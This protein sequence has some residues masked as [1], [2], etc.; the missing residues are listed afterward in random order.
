MVRWFFMLQH[1]WLSFKLRIITDKQLK[2]GSN[3]WN[4]H[5]S[6]SVKSYRGPNIRICYILW[7]NWLATAL[8]DNTRW[9]RTNSSSP[10]LRVSIA[11]HWQDLWVIIRI[12]WLYRYSTKLQN[13]IVGELSIPF[14]MRMLNKIILIYEASFVT[15]VQE[16]TSCISGIA[17]EASFSDCL[18]HY[19]QLVM[20]T[21]HIVYKELPTMSLNDSKMLLWDNLPGKITV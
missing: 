17:S 10:S 5:L 13:I 1:L 9:S 8:F 2:Q 4:H 16:L 18:N 7:V 20:V 6:S 12:K 11:N 3:W 21:V 15:P 14:L 19:L